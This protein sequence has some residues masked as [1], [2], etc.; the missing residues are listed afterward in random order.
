MQTVLKVSESSKKFKTGH[1]FSKLRRN[2]D[3]IYNNIDKL[4]M[5]HPFLRIFTIDLYQGNYELRLIRQTCQK[6]LVSLNHN[7]SD[8]PI[9]RIVKI[10]KVLLV[11]FLIRV[12]HSLYFPRMSWI[13]IKLCIVLSNNDL[14]VSTKS[15][16]FLL[17]VDVQRQTSAIHGLLCI[18][19]TI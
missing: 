4:V 19:S 12:K 17:S 18:V 11:A 5:K 13:L 14:D 9:E 8:N 1:L 10:L 6:T 2:T 7:S 16:H 3:H 15:S